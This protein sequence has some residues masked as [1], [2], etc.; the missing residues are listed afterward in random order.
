MFLKF[1]HLNVLQPR[2]R[3]AGSAGSQQQASYPGVLVGV[4][5]RLPM[6]QI[7]KMWWV[8]PLA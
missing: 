4:S 6:R 2:N 1:C 5:L 3:L 8:G 7:S